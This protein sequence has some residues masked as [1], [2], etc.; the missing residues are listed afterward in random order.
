MPI[1]DDA[2]C[3]RDGTAHDDTGTEQLVELHID[4]IRFSI[5][6]EEHEGARGA[7]IEHRAKRNADTVIASQIEDGV[8]GHAGDD[9]VIGVEIHDEREQPARSSG[10]ARHVRDASGDDVPVGEGELDT[11]GHGIADAHGGG[12]GQLDWQL[13]RSVARDL[14]DGVPGRG[15]LSGLESHGGHGPIEGSQEGRFGAQAE[16]VG[17]LRCGRG[18]RG[19]EPFHERASLLD[20]AVGDGAGTVELFDALEIALGL[21]ESNPNFCEGGVGCR[22][23][24]LKLGG[25]DGS[26]S[27]TFADALAGIDG[28]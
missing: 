4:A 1:D 6:H 7:R 25:I 10:G 11:D 27:L 22:D 5:A 18:A 17:A 24:V 13:E 15:E 20:L 23:G 26:Q 9:A 21:V 16:G 19:V 2:I 28:A 12:L 8:R 14:N 3:L